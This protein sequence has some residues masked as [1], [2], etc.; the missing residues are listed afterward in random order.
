MGGTETNGKGR[1]AGIE[2]PYTQEDVERLRGR[3]RV[4][5]TIARL[6]AE[7]LWKLMQ[8]EPYVAALGALTGAQAVQMVKAGLKAIYLS[9]W[10]VAADGNLSAHTYPD[11]SLYPGEQRACARQAHEQRAAPR[12]PDRRSRRQE[13]HVLARA[14]PRGRRSR[15]RRSSE[16]VRAH[17]VV[18][19]GRGRRR[20][21]RGPA[22][23][24]E[25]VRPPGREGA[26]PDEPLHPH[27]RLRSA[28][29]RRARRAD[30]PRRPH[31]RALRDAAHERRRRARPRVP[32]RASAPPR[33]SSAS[34][35]ESRRRSRGRSPTRRTPICS[36]ARPRRPTST[37]RQRSPRR[38]MLS[39]R[40]SCSRTTARRPSTGGSTSTTRRSRRSSR[41]SRAWATG[42]SS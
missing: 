14:R 6:G 11:Q 4:E 18:H 20:A 35:P 30:G 38:C 12:R 26:H 41:S 5:H 13:R 19:R 33:A 2:R 23:V 29:G 42:S 40:A 8:T 17:E 25:E 37:R 9:G 3:F 28:R 1:F 32:D 22:L 10:Q 27:A 21:L 7:R 31:R 15:L 36:G 34:S 24:R 16:R 39:T